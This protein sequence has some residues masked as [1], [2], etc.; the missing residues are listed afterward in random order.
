[1]DKF[2]YHSNHELEFNRWMEENWF[3]LHS[4]F[5]VRGSLVP[6]NEV[7]CDYCCSNKSNDLSVVFRMLLVFPQV[8]EDWR[9]IGDLLAN[10]EDC[11]YFPEPILRPMGAAIEVHSTNF[12]G[13]EYIPIKESIFLGGKD[14]RFMRSMAG[15]ETLW[16]TITKGNYPNDYIWDTLQ[17]GSVTFAKTFYESFVNMANKTLN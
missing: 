4:E 16:R 7:Y 11:Q 3:P 15:G 2:T 6:D 9:W 5:K 14:G 10:F 17:S 12:F 1:M 8:V 13:E